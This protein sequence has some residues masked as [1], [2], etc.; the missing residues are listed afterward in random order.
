[1]FLQSAVLLISSLLVIK[2][3]LKR[4]GDN[5]DWFTSNEYL[6]TL[7]DNITL[8][9][10]ENNLILPKTSVPERYR[11]HIDARDLYE[12]SKDFSGEVE[13]DVVVKK[14][15]DRIIIHSRNQVI[16]GVTVINKLDL[17][18]IPLQGFSLNPPE[19]TLTINFVNNV[20][21]STELILHVNYSTT[22]MTYEAGFYQKSYVM[23][24]R[25]SYLGATQFQATEARF[26]FPLYDEPALKAMFELRITHDERHHAIA[27][28]IGTEVSKYVHKIFKMR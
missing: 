9:E 18:E 4:V 22:M 2:A 20:T 14:S 23:N 21:A 25:T 17:L 13:I 3:S 11:I 12:G 10:E 5:N 15:T 16:I 8:D 27:N 19:D 1:M 6:Q 7:R 26:A 24:N 28:T